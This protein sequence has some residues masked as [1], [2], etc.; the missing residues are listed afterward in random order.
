MLVDWCDKFPIGYSPFGSSRKSKVAL[1]FYRFD[2][3]IPM[4]NDC[5]RYFPSPW[6][7]LS[8]VGVCRDENGTQ[9][10]S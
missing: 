1:R 6:V 10:I 9:T 3:S 5:Q 2:V 7:P 4:D 8:R